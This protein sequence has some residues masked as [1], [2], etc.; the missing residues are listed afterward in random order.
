M[1]LFLFFCSGGAALVYEVIW[2]KYLA[3][4]FG[5]TI[6][7]QT[8]VL[9]VFMGGLALG[10]KL[11]SRRAD[12]ARRPLVIY[13]GIELAIGLYAL[14][15]PLLYEG[16]GGIFTLLGA[17]LLRHAGWLLLLKGTLSVALLA[18]PTIL[19][20]GTLPVLA[21][22]LQKNTPDAGRRSA[23]FYSVNSLGA[24]AGAGLAGFWLIPDFGL[25]VTANLTA[26]VNGLI[27]LAALALAKKISTPETAAAEE[28]G[29]GPSAPPDRLLRRG[30]VVVALSG[31]VSM[32]LEVLAARCLS[33]IFGSSLQA[34]AIVLMAFI[35]GI[36]AGS[37][38]I[39]A[40]RRSRWPEGLATAVLLLAA[41]AL[42]GLVVVN[43]QNLVEFYRLARSGLSATS[44]GYDFYEILMSLISLGVLGLPAAALGAVLPL[45]IR[46]VSET[47]SLL[48]DR[49][50]RLLTWNT[51]GAVAGV[52]LTGFALMPGA[53]LRG[54]FVV[55]ALVPAGAAILTAL[56]TR[57][58]IA[59]A[60]GVIVAGL[61]VAAAAAGDEGWRYALTAGVFRL[62]ETDPSRL[63]ITE[64]AK[65]TQLL[66]Y[67]D[68][69]DATVSVERD[70]D[71]PA[72]SELVLRINGK[73]DASSHGD[74]STQ[75]LLGQLP[76]MMK[77][78]SRDVFCFGLG[79][80]ITAGTALGY[81]IEHLNV[82]ENC[83]PVLRAARLFAPWNQ[84]ALTDG[85]VHIFGEDARTVLMLSPQKYDAIIAE[86][87]NPWV[88]NVGSVF[89]REFYRLAASRLKPG[90]IMTQWFHTYEMDDA[91]LNLV[92]RTFAQTFPHMEIW[93]AS[94][95]DII[96]LGSD[97]PWQ[98][99]PAVF[100]RAF[101]LDGPR[102]DLS[103]IG[104]TT[105]QAMLAR[106]LASQSTA[107]AVA[108]PGP[109]QQD[110]FPLLEYA[111]PRAMYL[112][113]GSEA[114]GLQ[115][116]DERTY[117]SY[118]APAEKNRVLAQLDDATLKSVFCGDFGS[119]NPGLEE[120]VRLR[121][122][123]NLAP[124]SRLRSIP[125]VFRGADDVVV[126]EPAA[127]QTNPA[128]ERLFKA[129]AMLGS[130]SADWSQATAE[131]KDA[132][133]AVQAYAG[134]NA[135]WSPA[136]YA[137]LGA[138]MSLRIGHAAE[139]KAILQRGL[140]LEP[141]SPELGYVAR[142][143]IREGLLEQAE[144]PERK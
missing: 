73:A 90:G 5:S 128:V 97:R 47:S 78:D 92:L 52:L 70:Q 77:P 133:D 35:L 30:C 85:R 65:M 95:G 100:Q 58:R 16:M 40:R 76:L 82:A 94:A 18:G 72:F 102:R 21:A 20:G 61:L 57:Q 48:G 62:H 38:V 81:P 24:V 80:G 129:E 15:F 106:Q 44:M 74:L 125:C 63:P 143:M 10:N 23:R 19:M 37:A 12:R 96:L 124:D 27:G 14:I 140:Q 71:T 25:A 134:P 68:A 120:F 42:I 126:F 115:H 127:A 26:L 33:L 53:G 111:A 51:L 31:A 13:G 36:G 138:E 22:W 107:F 32:G 43:L 87:S 130:S 108:G 9:A 6:Q 104:L 105:P 11:F 123:G 112:Y 141:D 28:A 54:S 66:F 39:A 79:S 101:T 110:A 103:S 136:H 116:F 88:V 8:V 113:A 67:E 93:D 46:A 84:G 144:L 34:F 59:A 75:I 50:G 69:P 64:R 49:V 118:I 17:G 99:D 135:G 1:I 109:V 119:I 98:S 121:V 117:Q 89:S 55:L 2:S 132:L 29:P 83:E 139:A 91:T 122:G 142:I 60:A 4:L 131:I 45:W 137:Y 56:A 41:A 7:A 3:L 114:Q 86:P